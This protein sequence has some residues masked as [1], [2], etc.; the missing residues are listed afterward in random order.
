MRVYMTGFKKPVLVRLARFEMVRSDWRRYQYDL[1]QPGEYIATD[2]NSTSF[3]VS[4]VS[5]Q[6]NSNK[7]P[8]N[9]VMP[10]EIDQQQNV[11]TTNLVLLNEQSLSLRTFDLKD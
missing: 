9:Y 6:E 10:P 2:N 5:L 8:V 1:R 3:D 11:Q 7:T 4:A